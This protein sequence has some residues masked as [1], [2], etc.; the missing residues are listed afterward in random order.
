VR[1]RG[2]V[3]TVF[4]WG[5]LKER[6]HLGNPGVNETIIIIWIFKKWNVELQTESSW[7]RIVTGGGHL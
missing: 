4:W 2:E 5:K 6:D 1:I 7:V 3:Y